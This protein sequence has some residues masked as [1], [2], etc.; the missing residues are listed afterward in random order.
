MAIIIENMKMPDNCAVCPLNE[1]E[2]TFACAITGKRYN[3]W[4]PGR[5]SDCPL[6]EVDEDDEGSGEYDCIA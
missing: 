4:D 3:W 2:M 5:R 6:R 1:Y